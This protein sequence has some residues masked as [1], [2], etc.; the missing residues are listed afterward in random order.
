V[1]ATMLGS[2]SLLFDAGYHSVD[3]TG[4]HFVN[5][6]S[7]KLRVVLLPQASKFWDYS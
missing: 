5:Q 7:L 2:C 6:A 3:Q 1:Y 4:T